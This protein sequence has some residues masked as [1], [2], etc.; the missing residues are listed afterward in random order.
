MYQVHLIV[1]GLVQGVCYRA[2]CK[3]EAI[4]LNLIGWVR[5]LS[6]GEVEVLAQGEK[7]NIE[8]L[9]EWCKKGPP[10]A[11]VNNLKIEWQDKTE[12]LKS[13]KII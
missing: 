5:N 2:N 13:F 11:R 3:E 4:K 12:D 6:S 10:H 9:I 8:N 1:S 7:E